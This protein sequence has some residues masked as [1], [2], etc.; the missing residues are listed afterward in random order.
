[1]SALVRC[2]PYVWPMSHS[3]YQLMPNPLG[4]PA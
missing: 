1:M 2:A 4:G 3:W